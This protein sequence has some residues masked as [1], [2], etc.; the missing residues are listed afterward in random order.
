[1]DGTSFH[2]DC[3]QNK[4]GFYVAWVKESPEIRSQK[5]RR[6]KDALAEVRKYHRE[7]VESDRHIEELEDAK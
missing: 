4:E 7:I 2:Y 6:R 1:M 3:K 5:H